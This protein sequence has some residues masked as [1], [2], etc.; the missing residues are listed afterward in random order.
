MEELCR[1]IYGNSLPQNGAERETDK[2]LK[3]HVKSFLCGCV[4]REYYE[5][6]DQ[7]NNENGNTSTKIS[8]LQQKY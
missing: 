4:E 1:R 3:A 5:H 6:N 7:L 2:T 8:N